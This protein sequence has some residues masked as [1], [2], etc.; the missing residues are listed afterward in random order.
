[1]VNLSVI[2]DKLNSPYIN[3]FITLITGT[4]LA[5]IITIG[6]S[7]LLSRI[8]N[9]YDFGHF[10][11]YS[12]IVAIISIISCLRYELAILLPDSIK[13]SFDL[14]NLSIVISCIIAVILLF[15]VVIY[16]LNFNIANINFIFL[17]PIITV[18]TASTATLNYFHNKIGQIK[19]NSTGRVVQSFFTVLFSLLF[20]RQ[21]FFNGLAISAFLGLLINGIYL[22]KYLP[23]R[24][25]R[26]LFLLPDY[27]KL[28]N[29]ALE[30]IKF[31]QNSLFPAILNIFS[32]Q[33]IIFFLM[34]NFGAI[35]TGNYFFAARII[36]LPS[37]LLSSTFSDIFYQD[38]VKRKKNKESI[39]PFFTKNASYL[40]LFSLCFAL[41]MYFLG[42][43]LF[44]FFFG[45][46]WIEAGILSK[47]LIFSFIAR[48]I[49]SPMTIIFT[50]FN[51]IVIGGY[52]QIVYF[53]CYIVCFSVLTL[54]KVNFLNS[55]ILITLMEI[56]VYSIGFILLSFVIKEYDNKI[57]MS[58]G[59]L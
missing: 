5:Q 12:S 45:G 48:F 17:I 56:F 49:V 28:K 37:S 54:L 4:L 21:H 35:N 46:N 25:K 42:P 50:A 14:V 55:I 36:L 19:I 43:L 16:S 30:Y 59:Q 41:P 13:K 39:W 44:K 34:S 6:S 18:L 58:I 33:A 1:M 29:I 53:F 32:T 22:I 15:L 26:K 51:K 23:S 7:P 2:K 9:P 8:Y 27:I 47:I 31:P 38:L 40:L 20:S 52:W 24:Y 3:N 11:V 57:T 10:S